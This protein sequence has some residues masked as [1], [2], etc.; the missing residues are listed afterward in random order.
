MV[1][2]NISKEK[3]NKDLTA[4]IKKMI[5]EPSNLEV[6]WIFFGDGFTFYE[7]RAKSDLGGTDY[8]SLINSIET[9]I[10]ECIQNTLDKIDFST[11]Q[12]ALKDINQTILDFVLNVRDNE[13]YEIKN[14]KPEL[15]VGFHASHMIF[16]RQ[17]SL[18]AFSKCHYSL[19]IELYARCK[20][21]VSLIVEVDKFAP[22]LIEYEMSVSNKKKAKTRWSKHNQTRPEKKKQYLEIMDQENF[23]TFAE[24]AE[25]IKQHIETDKKPSYDTIKRWLSQASKGDFS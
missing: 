6:T 23:T 5:S 24:T 13:L 14:E 11:Y 19:A 3:L 12:S 15:G 1:M 8:Y 2:D 25:H 21:V 4:T 9:D 18:L 22:K 10:N 16:L 17:M 20:E 7:S